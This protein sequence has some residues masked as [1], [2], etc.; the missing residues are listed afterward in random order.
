VYSFKFSTWERSP[1]ASF[2]WGRVFLVLFLGVIFRGRVGV[3]LETF[4]DVQLSCYPF[5]ELERTIV[6][7]E[8][9][10]LSELDRFQGQSQKDILIRLFQFLLNKQTKVPNE[11]NK[12]V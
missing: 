6:S 5:H 4:Y 1:R 9:K 3:C 12:E 7:S 11:S 2:L 8:K 10:I